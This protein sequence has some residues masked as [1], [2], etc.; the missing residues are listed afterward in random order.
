MD[1]RDLLKRGTVLAGLGA[2]GGAGLVLDSCSSNKRQGP[3]SVKVTSASS[4]RSSSPRRG[5]ALV[6]GTEAEENGLSPFSSNFDATGILYARAFYDPL[7]ATDIHGNT[8]PYLARSITPNQDFTKWQIVARDNVQ[9]HDGSSLDADALLVNFK[10]HMASI[11]SGPILA[12]MISSITKIDSMTVEIAMNSPWV[13]FDTYLCGWIGAQFA[14]VA[15]PKAIAQGSLD[16]HPVGTGPFV[17]SNWEPGDHLLGLRN[18]K[19]WRDP[20]P[21]VDSVT[22]RPLPLEQSRSDALKA[23][24]ISIAHFTDAPIY[25]QLRANSDFTHVDNLNG[26]VG[27]AD[28]TFIMLNTAVPP[29]NDL[30]VR[31]GLAYLI[32]LESY[33]KV[34]NLGMTAIDRCAFQLGSPYH[35]VG[36]YPNFSIAQGKALLKSYQSANQLSFT[37]SNVE[38]SNNLNDLSLI[39]SE[40]TNASVHVVEQQVQQSKYIINALLGSYQAYFWR[41]F[42]GTDPD[43]NYDWWSSSF[44][45]PVGTISTN[46]ARNS[47]PIIDKALSTGRENPDPSARIEAYK[48]VASRLN[49]DVPY[50]WQTRALWALVARSNVQGYNQIV[51]PDGSIGLGMKSGIFPVGSVWFS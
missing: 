45:R 34:V 10:T 30:R 18:N 25:S 15:S 3:A 47:D 40:F 35:D 41:Q 31:K 50:L 13:P 29:F 24:D 19:Y 9:F 17:F 22:F 37:L 7:A 42:G 39:A 32:N 46:F 6:V 11:L 23:G 43:Q 44:A 14:Y 27:Q 21:Y 36:S 49:S 16:N 28:Q 12:P 26:E 8:K 51:L 1:R 48:T 38:G 2:L 20:M 4:Q 5:G 33:N